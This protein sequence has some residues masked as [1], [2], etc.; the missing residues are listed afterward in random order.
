MPQPKRRSW[1]SAWESFGAHADLHAVF[2]GDPPQDIIDEMED[3]EVVL[4]GESSDGDYIA[5]LRRR[6]GSRS[7]DVR[8]RR[9]SRADDYRRR[10]STRDEEAGNEEA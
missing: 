1:L 8:S 10:E 4:G 9:T 3:P 5:A 2:D 7:T 6:R